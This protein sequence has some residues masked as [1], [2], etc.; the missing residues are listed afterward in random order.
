[1]ENI[2]FLNSYRNIPPS[3]LR[4]GRDGYEK[5]ELWNGF[6]TGLIVAGLN[7]GVHL[8]KS[9]IAFSRLLKNYP[10]YED[11]TDEQLLTQMNGSEFE[12]ARKEGAMYGCALRVSIAL[13]KSGYLIPEIKGITL[14]D[15]KY[16]YILNAKSLNNYLSA[17]RS[18]ASYGIQNR[19]FFG[20]KGIIFFNMNYSDASGHITL[21]N[22][23]SIVGGNHDSTYYINNSTYINF[24][25]YH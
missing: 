4:E 12:Q 10:K 1:M 11:I 2:R 15:G 7:H 5:P 21:W 25:Q 18:I 16:N 23:F 9:S 13:N 22:R 19:N 14:S 24:Y 8:V 17:N 20:N 3:L 6:K